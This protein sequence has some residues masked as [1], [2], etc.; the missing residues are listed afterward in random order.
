[1]SIIPV[2]ISDITRQ[3]TKQIIEKRLFVTEKDAS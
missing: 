1:M 2:C 3:I